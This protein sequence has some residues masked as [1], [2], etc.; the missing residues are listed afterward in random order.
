MFLAQTYGVL[1]LSEV[2]FELTIKMALTYSFGIPFLDAILFKSGIA[3]FVAFNLW[4][5]LTL[6]V[7]LCMES[8]GAFLHSLRLH[9]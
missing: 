4:L 3:L 5:C 6:G 2:F 7:L 1:E 8:L 9:W